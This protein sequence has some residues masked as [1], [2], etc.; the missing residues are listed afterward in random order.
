LSQHFDHRRARG[1]ALTDSTLPIR[2]TP[3]CKQNKVRGWT[4]KG[5]KSAK[6]YIWFLCVLCGENVFFSRAI[7]LF[8]IFR[9]S[10]GSKRDL[11]Q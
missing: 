8:P 2:F 10:I 1:A 11:S 6:F 7:S 5:A 9:V 4:A 3:R